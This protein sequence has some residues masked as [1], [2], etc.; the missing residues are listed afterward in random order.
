YKARQVSLNRLVALKL[1]KDA[2][3][4]SESDRL[5]FQNEAEAVAQLDHP[6]IVPIYEVGESRGRRYFSMKL[7]AGTSLDKHLADFMADPR[8][9]ARLVAVVAEAVQHAHERGILHR[10]LKPANI[11][12]DERGEPHVTDFGLAKRITADGALTLSGAILG[13]PQYMSPEQARGNK[14]PNTTATDVYG[15]GSILY[16]LLT[17]RAPFTPGSLSEALDLVRLRPPEPPSRQ[18]PRV[19]R[20]LEVICLKCLEKEPSRRYPGARA[21]AEDLSRWLE[22]RPIAAR[23]VGLL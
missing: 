22:G 14:G 12:M 4:A 19:P 6:Q 16:A 2:E 3:F 5:R 9:A 10:D 17:G 15:L 21:L 20:D 8:A 13:T 23:P 1:I 11:L 18:N 7:I